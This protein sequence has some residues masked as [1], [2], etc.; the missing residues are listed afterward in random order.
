MLDPPPAGGI[1]EG[2]NTKADGTGTA[3]TATKPVM[4]NI[5]VYAVWGSDKVARL[6]SGGTLGEYSSLQAAIDAADDA[7]VTPG[8]SVTNPTVIEVLRS[9]TAATGFSI[10]ADKHIKL[11]VEAGEDWTI[12][13]KNFTLFD[14]SGSLTL[15]GTGGSLTLDGDSAG[16]SKAGSR[17]VFINSTGTL[18]MG[19]DVTLTGFSP[20]QSNDGGGVYVSGG[21]FTMN[22]GA[23]VDNIT[24]GTLSNNGGGGVYVNGGQFTMT[25][26]IIARNTANMTGTTVGGGGVYVM[27]GSFAMSGGTI[28]NNTANVTG[29]TA[30]GGGVYVYGG[31]FNMSGG[32]IYGTDET[33]PLLPNTAIN[34]SAAVFV[35]TTVT[36]QYVGAY[37]GGVFTAGDNITTT[38][39]TI[40]GTV[41][42]VAR[43]LSGTGGPAG[44]GTYPSLAAALADVP[45]GGSTPT[46]IILFKDVNTNDFLEVTSFSGTGLG[47]NLSNKKIKLTASGNR[48]INLDAA[49]G[50]N[51]LFSLYDASLILN[52]SSG[53]LTLDGNNTANSGGISINDDGILEMNDGV[54]ITRFNRTTSPAGVSVDGSNAKFTMNGGVIENNKITSA[55]VGGGVN[56]SNGAF[57]MNSG[58][59]RG[60]VSD[61][62]GGGVYVDGGASFTMNGGT[63][64]GNSPADKN[65]AVNGGGVYVTGAGSTFT[66]KNGKIKNNTVNN[67]SL[68]GGG[69]YVGANATFIMDNGKITDNTANTTATT[70]GGGG[71]VFVAGDAIFTM[72]G[73]TISGNKAFGTGTYGGGG[74]VFVYSTTTSTS[75]NIFTMTGGTIDGNETDGYGGGVGVYRFA[76][77]LATFTMT[78]GTISGNTAQNGGGV[79]ISFGGTL[80]IDGGTIEN[81]IATDNGGG[82][83]RT[84]AGQTANV[85][86]FTM[87]GGTI[88]GVDDTSNQNIANGATPSGSSIYVSG[89]TAEY[90]GDYGSGRYN[91]TDTIDTTDNTIPPFVAQ[92]GTG[93][94]AT[95]YTTLNEAIKDAAGT[96]TIVIIHDIVT[97]EPGMDINPITPDSGYTIASGKNITLIN[98]AAK[99]MKITAAAGNFALFT[100]K[101]SLTL[102][103]DIPGSLS[104]D[105]KGESAAANRRGVFVDGG[106]LTMRGVGNVQITG[107]K[108]NSSDGGGGVYITG[109]NAKFTMEDGA[110]TDNSAVSGGGVSVN[111]ATANFTMEKGA[112]INNTATSKGGGVSV[113]NGSFIM[114]GGNVY[115]IDFTTY[116]W[117][118]KAPNG[119]NT[120][121]GASL[122]VD[123]TNGT[124]TYDNGTSQIA[125]PTTNNT[126]PL[127]YGKASVV[128][129]KWDG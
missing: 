102:Q 42:F 101:G 99:D 109:A 96:A 39:S 16:V 1:L 61:S 83:Y 5:T 49:S 126:L 110:I 37:G 38:F 93:T 44:N 91:T 29:T 108:N 77:F 6:V 118:N 95:K 72:N 73:G 97:P 8:T 129:I 100:V 40:P 48:V 41:S 107:F 59:I 47:Y 115:G 69:V 90:A 21:Q 28:A 65:T 127:T 7:S 36:A 86:T 63:I 13:A 10:P 128:T 18:V 94:T 112:I 124:A 79:G 119:T 3:F 25:D 81:N 24:E 57:I 11:T 76:N 12:T 80:N 55:T 60:N 120:D 22:G 58:I 125:I 56:V 78:S 117:K 68:G 66:M 43:I 34:N 71:G 64:G 82:V 45:T 84:T 74:G 114:E 4:G 122:F 87:S 9:F 35:S 105:G 116:P 32:T 106:I 85:G 20:D 88:Y 52:G 67:T 75:L 30:G 2:W 26:G 15:D 92:I 103:D 111:G 123:P 121:T 104:L 53:T 33:D 98:D 62:G 14:V 51:V 31:T 50:V 19:G 17:G 27:S 54:F 70:A 46:E 113:N 23:I 89:G